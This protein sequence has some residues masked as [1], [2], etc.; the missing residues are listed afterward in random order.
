MDSATDMDVCRSRFAL[1]LQP[2]LLLVV[3]IDKT[4][5]CDKMISFECQLRPRLEI[6]CSVVEALNSFESY[7]EIAH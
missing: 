7:F 1:K 6:D 5:I 2:S 4:V 3:P